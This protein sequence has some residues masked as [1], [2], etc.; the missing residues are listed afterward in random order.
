MGDSFLRGFGTENSY[1]KAMKS[2]NEFKLKLEKLKQTTK[3]IDDAE[4]EIE[5]QNGIL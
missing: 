1:E 5:E 3:Q 2:I 4:V